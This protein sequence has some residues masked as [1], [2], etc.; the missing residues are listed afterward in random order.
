MCTA[1]VLMRFIWLIAPLFAKRKKD[2]ILECIT[3]NMETC[4]LVH[5][6]KIKKYRNFSG[7]VKICFFFYMALNGLHNSYVHTWAYLSQ[8]YFCTAQDRYNCHGHI[9][10]LHFIKQENPAFSLPFWLQ[11]IIFLL[12]SY[13]FDYKGWYSFIQLTC[14][15]TRDDIPSFSLTFW[16]QGMIFLLPAYHF[17][18]KGWYF[19]FQL[20]FLTTRDDIPSSSWLFL[21]QGMIFLHST[22]LFDCKRWYSF[23]QLTFMTASDDIPSF[24][25]PLW[26][27][28]MIFLLPAYL[29]YYKGCYSFYQ[30]TLWTTRCAGP[31]FSWLRCLYVNVLVIGSVYFLLFIGL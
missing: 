23:F 9:T 26:L 19:F 3:I 29:F 13:L 8:S 2:V 22:Y 21:L 20:T 14:L 10:Y 4:Q 7:C 27:Q 16:L 24:S 6:N 1:H 25:W 18:Y 17:D 5:K 28:G 11:G 12:S 15:T 31:A 30:L